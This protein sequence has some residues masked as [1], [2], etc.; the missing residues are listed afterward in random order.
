MFYV[1]GNRFGRFDDAEPIID[2]F[3]TFEQVKEF[4]EDRLLI[5]SL[6]S[7]EPIPA[8]VGGRSFNSE[9]AEAI[10]IPMPDTFMVK[11]EIAAMAKFVEELEANDGIFVDEED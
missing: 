6:D 10:V 11:D 7:W 3:D 4:M 1:I 5:S 8:I 2:K 9:E